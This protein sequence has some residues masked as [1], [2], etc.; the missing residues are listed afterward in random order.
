MLSF[1]FFIG[2]R[3]IESRKLCNNKYAKDNYLNQ[4][5]SQQ[6]KKMKNERKKERR[7][8]TRALRDGGS[9]GGSSSSSASKF[10]QQQDLGGGTEIMSEVQKVSCN[11]SRFQRS[12]RVLRVQYYSDEN[13]VRTPKTLRTAL[14]RVGKARPPTRQSTSMDRFWHRTSMVGS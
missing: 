3:P 8:R 12:K 14:E 4:L 6:H 2:D 5:T 11:E 7:I 1:V 10:I 13:F 9:D